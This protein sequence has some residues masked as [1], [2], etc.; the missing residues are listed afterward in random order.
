MKTRLA[1]TL[2]LLAAPASA[3]D[4]QVHGYVD[5]RLVAAPDERSWTDGGF[6]KTRYGDGGT[7][8]RFGAAGLILTGQL[9][10][11]LL[12][13][14]DVQLHTTDQTRLELVEAYLRYRPVSL[15]PWRWS[16]KLGAFFPPVSL[17]NDAIGWTNPWTLTSSAINSWVGEELRATGA[18][19][20]IERRGGRYAWE[21]AVG[22]FG[23]NDPAG[24]LLAARG[25][26]MS[27]LVG[28]F[29]RQLREPDEYAEY[30]AGAEAPLRYK[31]FVELDHR[32]GWYGQLAVHSS[33]LGTLQV[34]RYDNRADPT[35]SSTYDGHTTFA[36]RTDFWSVGARTRIGAVEVIAQ[37]MD[38]ETVI[39]PV[40]Y[41]TGQFFFHAGY[42]MAGLAQGAWRPALRV[43][44]FS[45]RQEPAGALPASEHGNA[46]T[47]AL[48]WR[49]R[50]WLRVTGEVL[51]VNSWRQRRLW[52][53][54]GPRVIDTQVQVGVRVLF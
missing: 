8:G 17:E 23:Y 34:L 6:G 16:L 7:Q 25:W 32:P 24:E 47:A 10:P 44:F 50:E 3:Q 18:E 28:G 43:D 54:E 40:P 45:L 20:R 26:S 2:L 21:A 48:N 29:G 31:P 49:P 38:G 39:K 53:G 52:M 41:Y 22:L 37:A 33:E 35:R 5:W 42:V 15:T 12:G 13:H 46:L 9:A 4:W 30:A 27:D 36:W 1:A 11:S 51:R 19:W 14:A